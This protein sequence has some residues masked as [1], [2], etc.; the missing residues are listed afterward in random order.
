MRSSHMS[1]TRRHFVKTMILGATALSSP[2]P[3]FAQ[4]IGFQMEAKDLGGGYWGYTGV[5]GSLI[6][7]KKKDKV[8]INFTNN[9]P[10]QAT[11]VHWHGLR[12][13]N[14]MDGVPFITQDPIEV[15]QSFLYEF[16]LRDSGTYFF[17]PHFNTP[18]QVERGLKGIFIVEEDNPPAVNEEHILVIDDILLDEKGDIVNI[19]DDSHD[20]FHD[21]RLGNAYRLNGQ[22]DIDI[23]VKYG[24]RLRLRMVCGANARIF[25]LDFKGL[26][27]WL[28][29]KDG[30]SVGEPIK[31]DG[32]NIVFGSGQRLDIIL[33]IDGARD[34]DYSIYS[35][36][37][38]GMRFPVARFVIDGDEDNNELIKQPPLALEKNDLPFDISEKNAEIID[39][40]LRGGM[41][42]DRT[43]KMNRA[44]TFWSIGN[45]FLS[46]ADKNVDKGKAW[47]FKKGKDYIL[48]LDNQTVY[49]HPMHM[50]GHF[51]KVLNGVDK[52]L[53]MDTVM[54]PAEETIDIL[55]RAEEIGKWMF[56]CH[57]L[58]HAAS[59]MMVWYQVEK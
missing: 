33:D 31:L 21:G 12:L 43:R 49:D 44:E 18:E 47:T 50:H 36:T 10:A 26:N 19:F 14:A 13:P 48:R 41:M 56:H 58:E 55:F 42:G 46:E 59:G 57:I 2:L 5:E 1:M 9:L 4:E 7:Q 29:A 16:M 24:Q 23:K 51:F 35:T 8:Q 38:R 15:G 54:V 30:Q 27:A 17:H 37:Y 25:N 53:W 39:A 40:T 52:G 34:G 11:S 28:L 22:A 6:R 32:K 3:L 45:V 20:A